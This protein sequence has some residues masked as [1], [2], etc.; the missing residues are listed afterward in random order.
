MAVAAD[1]LS[2]LQVVFDLG[3]VGVG[4]AVV[5]QR[6]E[7]LHR[8]PDTHLAAVQRSELAPLGE[9]EIAGLVDVIEAVELADD[10]GRVVIHA[11]CF[12][13]LARVYRSPTKSSQSLSAGKGPLISH[14]ILR[15]FVTKS[16]SLE[17]P[18]R[19]F[20]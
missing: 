3:E 11:I 7:V 1:G 17:L 6:V 10:R 4:I 2:G 8:F 18:G 14:T 15:V 16:Y 13:F 20:R 9:S 5:Y 12:F 19:F